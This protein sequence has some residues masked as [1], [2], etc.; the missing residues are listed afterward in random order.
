MKTSLVWLSLALPVWLLADCSVQAQYLRPRCCVGL[1]GG[2]CGCAR[3]FGGLHRTG[4]L[5][6][7]GPYFPSPSYIDTGKQNLFSGLHDGEGLFS[8]LGDLFKSD[9]CTEDGCIGYGQPAI[10]PY[11]PAVSP[12]PSVPH[13]YR[14]LDPTAA[15]GRPSA[16]QV[17]TVSRSSFAPGVASIHDE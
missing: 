4:P 5:F 2:G 1:G 16:I 11:P 14:S 7:Y 9:E 3:L 17:K 10:Y 6:N 15:P 8:R 12:A 13:V